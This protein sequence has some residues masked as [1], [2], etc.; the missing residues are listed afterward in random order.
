MKLL[1]L[2]FRDESEYGESETRD[3]FSD[4]YSE[5]SESDKLSRSAASDEGGLEHDAND[6]LGYLY[7]QHF[8]RSAPYARVP[9]MDKVT[10]LTTLNAGYNDMIIQWHVFGGYRSMSWLE[11]TLDWCR[12]EASIFHRRVGWL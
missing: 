2:W 6:R 10:K 3:S 12:W 11:G 7:L 5:E 8:E 9:L 1:N 4:S